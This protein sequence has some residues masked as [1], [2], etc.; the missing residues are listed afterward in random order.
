[1]QM[2][3]NIAMWSKTLGNFI[4]LWS[5]CGDS[6]YLKAYRVSVDN[7]LFYCYIDINRQMCTY[8][9]T[10]LTDLRSGM[11]LNVFYHYCVAK[12]NSVFLVW[13]LWKR[14]TCTFIDKLFI[15]IIS[16]LLLFYHG[17]YSEGEV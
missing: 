15:S 17:R 13:Y 8:Q 7:V 10:R 11:D 2:N 4:L 14:T 9:H 16:F 12:T 5:F 3:V 1:M 6:P